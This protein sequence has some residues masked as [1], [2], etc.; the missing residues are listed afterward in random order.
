[1]YHARAAGQFPTRRPKERV[2]EVPF[3][4]LRDDGL[5]DTVMQPTAGAAAF[6]IL[7]MFS[8]PGYLEGRPYSNGVSICGTELLSFGAGPMAVA[9]GL[10]AKG[11]R[12]KYEVQATEFARLLAK[13]AYSFMV[14]NNGLLPREESP[15]LPIILQA[16]DDA[17]AWVGSRSYQLD[18][19][20][21]HPLHAL[22]IAQGLHRGEPI[23]LVRIKLFTNLG[24]TGYE[25]V[26][27][28]PG[29]KKYIA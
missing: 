22:A 2:K 26:V 21:E 4:V 10:G 18:I 24:A 29:W 8:L 19:E 14:A 1:M 5:S 25:I 20:A 15:L 12:A 11:V 23:T 3:T 9:Q 13:I 16:K 17:G 28:A 27:R 6:L 7:P